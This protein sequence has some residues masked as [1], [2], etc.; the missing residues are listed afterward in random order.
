MFSRWKIYSNNLLYCCLFSHFI[1]II[2]LHFTRVLGT[3]RCNND[4]EPSEKIKELMRKIWIKMIKKF[5]HIRKH[6]QCRPR[7]SSRFFRLPFCPCVPSQPTTKGLENVKIQEKI[8]FHFIYIFFR[9]GAIKWKKLPENDDAE[10]LR[11]CFYT[12][13]WRR[14]RLLCVIN[15]HHIRIKGTC[16]RAWWMANFTHFHFTLDNNNSQKEEKTFDREERAR[17]IPSPEKKMKKMCA[18]CGWNGENSRNL[19]HFILMNPWNMAKKEKNNTTHNF[20]WYW[21]DCSVLT[22]CEL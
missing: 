1:K 18:A 3:L 4:G 17:A 20:R 9:A 14:A 2:W 10:C 5:F 6:R 12:F 8:M 11:D 21:V 13:L 19:F 7:F 15:F 22:L 16:A